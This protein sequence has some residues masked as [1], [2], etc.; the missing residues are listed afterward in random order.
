MSDG[1]FVFLMA[2]FDRPLSC[3][4][5]LVERPD[6]RFA[7]DVTGEDGLDRDGPVNFAVPRLAWCG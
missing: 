2:V 6:C 3:G 7:L 5:D 4:E 1:D